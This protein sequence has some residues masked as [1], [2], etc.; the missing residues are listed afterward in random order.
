M[1]SPPLTQ[2]LYCCWYNEIGTIDSHS[3]GTTGECRCSRDNT[4][5]TSWLCPRLRGCPGSRD[6]DGVHRKQGVETHRHP[7][8]NTHSAPPHPNLL[9]SYENNSSNLLKPWSPGTVLGTV[10]R[11]TLVLTTT[12]SRRWGRTLTVSVSR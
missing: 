2:G 12:L 8:S 10:H 11:W 6:L 3:P 1:C 5:P 7:L 9:S 4:D